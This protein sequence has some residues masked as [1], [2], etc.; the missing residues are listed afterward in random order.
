MS[1]EKD[2]QYQK[3]RRAKLES[4]GLCNVCGKLPPLENKKQC[5]ECREQGRERVAK[6]APKRRAKLKELGLCCC[7]LPPRPGKLTCDQCNK[8]N[9]LHYQNRKNRGL[10]PHCSNPSPEGKIVC[11]DCIRR[12]Q[13]RYRRIKDEVFATYGGYVCACCGETIKKFLTIDH[14]NND[15]KQHRQRVGKSRVLY[16]WLH[17]NGFPPGFQVLCFNC[18]CGRQLNGGVCPHRA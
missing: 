12:R 13:S 1:T 8:K 16:Y 6:H 4:E 15:G 10:C 7:G 17:D 9:R 11:S 18:N 5:N 2:K 3:D 14:I